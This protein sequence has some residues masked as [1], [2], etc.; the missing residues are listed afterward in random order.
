[1]AQCRGHAQG[2]HV[3]DFPSFQ[4]YKLEIT[5]ATS[6]GKPEINPRLTS[7]PGLR[8]LGLKIIHF[9]FQHFIFKWLGVTT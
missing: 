5:T 9:H 7:L 2:S 1:M 6:E 3:S 4:L 8:S